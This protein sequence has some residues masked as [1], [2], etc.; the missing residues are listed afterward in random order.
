[1]KEE[2]NRLNKQTNLNSKDQKRKQSLENQLKLNSE[3]VRKADKKAQ[4][5]QIKAN[6]KDDFNIERVKVIG[7]EAGTQAVKGAA[8][9]ILKGLLQDLILSC[10]KAFKE[11]PKFTPQHILEAIKISFSNFFEKI[12]DQWKDKLQNSFSGAVTEFIHSIAT[13]LM[14]I[15]FKVGKNIIKMIRE[16][17]Q[18]ILTLFKVLF[19]PQTSS[20]DKL[21]EITKI[22]ATVAI[23]IGGIALEEV[24]N[25]FLR[26]TIPI[27][28]PFIDTI[29]AVLIAIITA[30]LV[31]VASTA[32]EYTFKDSKLETSI[33]VSQALRDNLQSSIEK[34]PSDSILFK[35]W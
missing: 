12:K 35:K 33:K 28:A 4:Q 9:Q 34:I 18:S 5:A 16:G 20:K 19:N 7:K 31:G 27:L 22:L 25:N 23:V 14:N 3:E 11:L 32:I 15:F 29:T 2:L 13:S 21:K 24:I 8:I 17:M 6:R 30:G 10:F 26:A 1:M